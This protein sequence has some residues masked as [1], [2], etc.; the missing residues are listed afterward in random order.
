MEELLEALFCVLSVPSQY[1]E[2]QLRLRE[3]SE[4]AVRRV[5]GWCEMAASL[6]VGKLQQWVSVRQSPASKIVNTEAEEA[7]VLEAVTRRQL[8]NI[9]QSEK[10][11]YVL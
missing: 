2:E 4:T 3:S 11:S 5:G 8:A 9:Q 1:N 10:T 6:G 7:M